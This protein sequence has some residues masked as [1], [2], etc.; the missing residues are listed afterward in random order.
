MQL[1]ARVVAAAAICA[2]CSLARS[3]LFSVLP[4]II[5]LQ[6]AAWC[7]EMAAAAV[8]I[9]VV[10]VSVAAAALDIINILCIIMNNAALL[11]LSHISTIVTPPGCVPALRLSPFFA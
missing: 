2:R 9:V 5:T 1:P 10:V 7:E 11:L 6:L 4:L 3:L 8:C